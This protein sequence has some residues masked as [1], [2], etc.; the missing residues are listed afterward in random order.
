MSI[1]IHQLTLFPVKPLPDIY[2][3]SYSAFID[4]D[5]ERGLVNQTQGGSMI[6]KSG[7]AGLA[8][9]ILQPNSAVEGRAGIVHGWN[10]PRYRFLLKVEEQGQMGNST[11]SFYT[12]H[13]E[14][15]EGIIYHGFDSTI[16]PNMVLYVNSVS[17][18][19]VG[20]MVANGV[21]STNFTTTGHQQFLFN[22]AIVNNGVPQEMYKMRP[23]D[24]FHSQHILN[25]LQYNGLTPANTIDTTGSMLVSAGE[26]SAR[27]NNLPTDYLYR[28]LKA[29]RYG[30]S[31][32]ESEEAEM[33]ENAMSMVKEGYIADNPFMYQMGQR[34]SS[35]L[36]SGTFTFGQLKSF[37]PYLD[38][39]T[40]VFSNKDMINMAAQSANGIVF[41]GNHVYNKEIWGADNTE[42][43]H[44]ST[45]ETIAAYNLSMTLPAMML[46][47]F[48]SSIRLTMTNQTQ[49]GTITH[50]IQS[51]TPLDPLLQGQMIRAG[52][53]LVD[54][55]VMELI[56]SITYQ[57]NIAFN[58][59]IDCDVFGDTLIYI[60]MNGNPAV[61]LLMPT[62]ADNAAAPVMTNNLNNYQDVSNN[63]YHLANGLASGRLTDS[64][65]YAN[66]VT[67]PSA[68][69][70]QAAPVQ[71]QQ[72][73]IN[74]NLTNLY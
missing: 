18:V 3:R 54:R 10:T 32:Y 23:E 39:I 1:K 49:D 5:I 57:G 61:P 35:V 73:I 60:S 50:A 41:D 11:I 17:R 43:W 71:P 27:S 48:V 62:F 9:Q 44:G 42:H 30:Q 7:L 8:S 26:I 55:L 22:N 14:H 47:K 46:D 36:T 24:V 33:I 21:P 15:N 28:T 45:P 72:P 40:A 63:I 69:P 19:R 34:A 13:T 58:C 12:G 29:M 37:C 31:D 59:M 68:Q 4:S 53:E 16:D 74:N 52:E 70:M 2:R 64:V 20:N 25:Q 65:Q 66:G 67:V 6:T 56:N 38:D 51:I